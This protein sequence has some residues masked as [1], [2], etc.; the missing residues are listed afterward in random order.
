MPSATI[1][2]IGA[3]HVIPGGLE[4]GRIPS[5]ETD[6]EFRS[7][8]K[9]KKSFKFFSKQ[10]ALA[11]VAA[12]RAWTQAAID[13]PA[14]PDSTGI[15]FCSGILPFDLTPMEKAI[16]L[17][18]EGGAFSYEKFS[19]AGYESMNPLLTFKCLPNMPLFHISANLGITGRYYM[20]YPGVPEWFTAFSRAMDDLEEGNITYAIVGAVADQRNHLV[21]HHV[22]RINPGLVDKLVDSAS[23]LVL[24]RG[25]VPQARALVR[26]VQSHYVP[27][28]PFEDMELLLIDAACFPLHPGVVEASLYF[29]LNMEQNR[30]GPHQY[31]WG[32]PRGG[33]CLLEMELL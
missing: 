13:D 8:L 26:R 24:T 25:V 27:F 3:G 7:L 1:S 20:T 5:G 31:R 14:Y 19:T 12:H 16:D 10:D 23:V 11:L 30:R 33:Y 4:E 32:G 2:V 22:R 17:S 18:L 9:D 28:D 6:F 29:S 21:R 15:Y